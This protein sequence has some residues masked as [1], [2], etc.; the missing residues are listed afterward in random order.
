MGRHLR[1]EFPGVIYHVTI[2][3]NAGQAIFSH[4]RDRERFLRRLAAGV[5]TY[6]VRLY[7]FCL[8]T[9]HVHLVVETPDTNLSRF[10]QNLEAGYTVYYNL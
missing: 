5:E 1:V 10:M 6:G 4:E 2:R 9:N 3:G 8:M 7:L